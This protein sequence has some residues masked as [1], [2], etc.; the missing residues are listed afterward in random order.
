MMLLEVHPICYLN[1]VFNLGSSTLV[2]V[3]AGKQVFPF[4]QQL[5]G[6]FLLR[7]GPFP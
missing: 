3:T 7:F 5:L 1:S 2:L 4:K 6:L